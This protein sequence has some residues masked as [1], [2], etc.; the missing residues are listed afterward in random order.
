MNAARAARRWRCTVPACLGL[1]VLVVG[2]CASATSPGA[3]SPP[4]TAPPTSAV[5]SPSGPLAWPT[6]QLVPIPPG[7]YAIAPPFEIPFTLDVPDGWASL[8]LH[9][10]FTDLGWFEGSIEG[11]PERIIA[12]GHPT[13]IRCLA[14]VRAAGLSAEDT[15]AAFRE[16]IDLDAGVPTPFEVDGRDGLW[17]DLRAPAYDTRVFSGPGPGGLGIGPDMVVRLLIVPLDD[18][19]LLLVTVHAAAADLETTW[20]RA[21]PILATIDLDH[22]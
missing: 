19:E 21:V 1:L 14:D 11:V 18:G 16:R 22:G 10:E 8:H 2:G 13:T 15:A 4:P 12:F 17:L 6:R 20:A 3:A 5:P 9:P 7:H